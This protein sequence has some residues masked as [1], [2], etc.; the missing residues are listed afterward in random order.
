MVINPFFSFDKDVVTKMISHRDNILPLVSRVSGARY[1]AFQT[2][3][4]AATFYLNAK[5]EGLVS[6][7]RDP[8]DDILFGPFHDAM[9]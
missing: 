8:G 6:V 9:Q 2:R 5:E 1:K 4:Q 7:V 3:E